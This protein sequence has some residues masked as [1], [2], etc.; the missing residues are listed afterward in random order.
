MQAGGQWRVVLYETSS[1]RQPVEEFIASLDRPTYAKTLR[2][3]E[4]LRDNGPDLGMP[5]SKRL[6]RN[7]AELRIRGKI[8][9]RLIYVVR[10]R[11]IYVLHGFIKKS[12]QLPMRE[13]RTA[14][15]RLEDVKR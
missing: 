5:H 7:L 6:D 12:Q 2:G 11:V 13:L 14:R 10:D 4:L 3:L 1:G 15:A 8:D 9:L